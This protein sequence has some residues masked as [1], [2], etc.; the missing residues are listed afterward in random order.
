MLMDPTS[1]RFVLT[2]PGDL[3]LVGVIRDLSTQAGTYAKLGSDASHAFAQQV[4]DATESAIAETAVQDAPIEF[5][6]FR[7][8]DVLRVT[9]AWR[10]NGTEQRRDVEHKTPS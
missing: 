3:R 8:P 9:L 4:V 2:M 5:R 1:F 10:A 7:S 6:F